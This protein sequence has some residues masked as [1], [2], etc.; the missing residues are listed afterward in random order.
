M[1][2]ARPLDP[3]ATFELQTLVHGAFV[4]AAADT[5]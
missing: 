4:M 1:G 5:R 3:A 2:K